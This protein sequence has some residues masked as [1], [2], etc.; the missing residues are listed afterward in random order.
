MEQHKKRFSDIALKPRPESGVDCLVCAT[1]ARQRVGFR[2]S[3]KGE[4][5]S[6]GARRGGA[7]DAAGDASGDGSGEATRKVDRCNAGWT[8]KVQL[9]WREAGPPDHHDDQVDSDQ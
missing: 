5:D 2:V 1:F 3:V 6:V 9:L 4:G 7:G 8:R